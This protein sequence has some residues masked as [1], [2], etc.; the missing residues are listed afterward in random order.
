MSLAMF[1][2]QNAGLTDGSRPSEQ[3]ILCVSAICLL[4]S[5]PLLVAVA[6]MIWGG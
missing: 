4:A 3:T 6:L 5:T 2:K 1:P